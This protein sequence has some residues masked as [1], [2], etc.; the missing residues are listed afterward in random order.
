VTLE[1]DATDSDLVLFLEEATEQ[2]SVLSDGLLRMERD[3]SDAQLIQAVFRAA[4]T[5]KGS[6]ATINHQRMAGLTHAMESVLDNIRNGILAPSSAVIDALLASVDALH[7]LNEEVLTREESEIEVDSLVTRLREIAGAEPAR[8]APVSRQVTPREAATVADAIVAEGLQG[9]EI[10][11]TIEPGSDW[12]AVRAFQ[13][14]M[15]LAAMGQIV[16]S[17]PSEQELLAGESGHS[18]SVIMTSSRDAEALKNAAGSVSEVASVAVRRMAEH[19]TGEARQQEGSAPSVVAGP[20]DDRRRIEL[21][22]ESRNASIDEQLVIAGTRLSRLS[23][24]VKVDITQLDEMMNLVGEHVIDRGR[25]Q[26]VVRRLSDTLGTNASIEGL[27]DITQHLARVSDEMQ[28][29]VMLFRLLPVESVFN[30]FPRMVRDL[31]RRSGKSVRYVI[32]G[33]QTG[34]DRS[35]IDEIGDPLLHL[36]RNAMDHGV[37]MPE[38]RMAA[39]KPEEATILLSAEHVESHIVIQVSDD[40]RGIDPAK[41]RATAVRR[42]ILSQEA[43]NRLSDE[44]AINLIFAPGFSSA[45]QV[46]DVS[47]RGVGMDIV[48]TNIEKIN[49]SVQLSTKLGVGT[50]FTITLPLTLAIIRALL[51]RVGEAVFTIPLASVQETMRIHTDSIHTVQG[52]EVVLVRERALPLVRLADV[53]KHPGVRADRQE[54]QWCYIAAVRSSGSELGLIVDG[55]IG[56]QEVVIKSLGEALGN[57]EGVAGAT[58]LGD[59]RVSMIVDVPKVIESLAAQVHAVVAA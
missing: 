27:T 43:A 29:R 31:A 25:L 42:G 7:V 15:E 23:R 36:L 12:P 19:S 28:E 41:M 51:V 39:G 5:L 2:L 55:L 30:R 9:Y 17:N 20:V 1:L 35:V 54:S 56:E 45:E 22:P 16:R 58:I 52:H 53:Y 14:L 44:E 49:G 21:G 34:L 11:V 26:Q 13:S 10:D 18:L 47:G 40:G 57:T 48:R 37:E 59:G 24:M 8:P 32:K 46:T 33:E 50:T 3:D 38:E 4:H 6:S